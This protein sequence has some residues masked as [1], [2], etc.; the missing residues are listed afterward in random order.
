MWKYCGPLKI[1]VSRTARRSHSAPLPVKTGLAGSLVTAAGSR[2][3]AVAWHRVSPSS[4]EG[5]AFPV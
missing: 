3:G 4:Y 1:S 2:V 5:V